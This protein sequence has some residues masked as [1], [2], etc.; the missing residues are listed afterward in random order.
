M[1]IPVNRDYF[2]IQP[3]RGELFIEKDISQKWEAPSGRYEICYFRFIRIN[4]FKAAVILR[5]RDGGCFFMG[6]RLLLQSLIT[7]IYM[8]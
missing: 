6:Y 5:G 4:Y 2:S 1:V 3:L 7:F 8:V